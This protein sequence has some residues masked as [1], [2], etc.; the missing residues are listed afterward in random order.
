MT[1]TL[2]RI[3]GFAACYVYCF[4]MLRLKFCALFQNGHTCI[5]VNPSGMKCGPKWAIIAP[6]AFRYSREH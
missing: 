4:V 2:R 6:A 3:P 1:V 5:T